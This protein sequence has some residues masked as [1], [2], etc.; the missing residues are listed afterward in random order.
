MAKRKKTQNDRVLQYLRTHKRGITQKQSAD[1]LGV[2]RLSARIYELRDAGNV[3]DRDWLVVQN[4]YGE[5]TRVA[6]YHLIKE[7]E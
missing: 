1:L 5:D 7:K 4:R 6:Q 3:I 2:T